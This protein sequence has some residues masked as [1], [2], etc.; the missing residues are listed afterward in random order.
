[1]HTAGVLDDGVTGSLTPERVDAVMRPKADAAWHLHEL[2]AGMDLD[3]FVLFSAAAAAF[4][5]AG[6]GSYA[7]ANAFLDGLAARRQTEGRPGVSLAWGLW[8]DASAMTGHLGQDDLARMNRGG[9][10]ALSAEHGLALLDAALARDEALLVPARLDVAGIRA[11]A[12]RGESLPALWRSLVPAGGPV[13]A[14]AGPASPAQAGGLRAD[15]AGLGEEQRTRV[16]GDVVRGCVAAVLGLRSAELVSP[17][18]A[19]KDLG[20]DSLTA[21]EL[22]N[23]LNAVTGLRL[24]ATLIFDC[25]T[26]GAVAVLL[27]SELAGG[28]GAGAAARL[29]VVAD[30]DRLESVLSGLGPG[31]EARE[32]ITRRLQTI[33]SKWLEAQGTTE[34][35]DSDIGFDSATPD[36]VFGFLDEEFGSS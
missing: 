10:R 34:S 15:L 2:T 28:A 14:Q 24:P 17:G 27:G 9:V 4:G 23:R 19:F 29:P 21:L 20:F 7:A 12:A 26:P 5:N 18:R 35:D 16:L 3:A 33:L 13:R 8:A 11:Q 22:R 36:E 25:P 30:L 6:Q 31:C 1:V 32:D